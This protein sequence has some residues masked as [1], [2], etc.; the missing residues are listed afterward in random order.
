MVLV[1]L[2]FLSRLLS[3]VE[4]GKFCVFKVLFSKIK[5]FIFS[6]LHIIYMYLVCM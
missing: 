5:S 4:N 3:N 2:T 1:L 6:S